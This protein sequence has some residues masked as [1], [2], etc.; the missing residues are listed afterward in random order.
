M[1][2]VVDSEAMTVTAATKRDF[3]VLWYEAKGARTL[4]R[5]GKAQPLPKQKP[6]RLAV[7]TV[8]ARTRDKARRLAKEHVLKRIGP[9][10]KLLS[11]NFTTRPDELLVYTGEKQEPK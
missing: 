2:R 1:P 3:R 9:M 11:V 10:R 6:T 5:G 4:F 7:F 8:T